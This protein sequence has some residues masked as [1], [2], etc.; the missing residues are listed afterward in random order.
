MNCATTNGFFLNERLLFTNGIRSDAV[1]MQIAFGRVRRKTAS[2]GLGYLVHNFFLKLTPMVFAI[3]TTS[4][5]SAWSA[6]Q[7]RDIQRRFAVFIHDTGVYVSL[8][9]I[10]DNLLGIVSSRGSFVY[11]SDL[12]ERSEFYLGISL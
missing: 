8:V 10:R 5:C 2:T 6:G 7:V 1:G 9:K 12:S 11:H 4:V 3:A